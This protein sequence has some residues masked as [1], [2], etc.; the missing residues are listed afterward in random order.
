M[1]GK[2]LDN[3][4]QD[5]TSQ[6]YNVM[7]IA[8]S[9]KESERRQ[10]ISHLLHH[11]L[12]LFESSGKE[13][14]DWEML[15]NKCLYYACQEVLPVLT[16]RYLANTHDRLLQE[17]INIYIQDKLLQNNFRRISSYKQD[18]NASFRTFIQ[19]VVHHLAIDFFRA[20][21]REN[22][23]VDHMLEI[24]GS[25]SK[26]DM[27]QQDSR[28]HEH[29][30][31][32]ESFEW[33]QGLLDEKREYKACSMQQ[34]IA[35]LLTL[36]VRE[37]LLLK[38]I[39]FSGLSAEQA[40]ALP[41]MGLSKHQANSLHRRLLDRLVSVFKEA[42]VYDEFQQLVF[43]SDHLQEVQVGALTVRIAYDQMIM[44]YKDRQQSQCYFSFHNNAT[45][46]D[47]AVDYV[48]LRKRLYNFMLDIR[49]N[50]MV[51][52]SFIEALNIKS[53]KLKLTLL[54]DWQSIQPHFMK[55]IKST[56]VTQSTN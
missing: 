53:K 41:G 44:V 36:D 45:Q 24:D 56:F 52:A 13:N 54:E 21:S 31:A 28:T 20:K 10:F 47:V 23:F 12:A 32:E 26:I 49:N 3:N 7:C 51:G 8:Y 48:L 29:T 2:V 34:K 37:R 40:G 42:G 35:Q 46:A 14:S 17:E 27:Q 5:L 19:R 55:K 43:E 16:R 1:Q 15:K 50:A 39:Y 30:F 25:D 22:K 11:E 18:K 38:A 4:I 6:L 33:I 9:L